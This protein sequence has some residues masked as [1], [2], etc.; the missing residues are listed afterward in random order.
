[1]TK[2]GVLIVME[3][4]E[5]GSRKMMY[6]SN[7]HVGFQHVVLSILCVGKNLSNTV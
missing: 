1:M 6:G 4:Y 5:I 2:S 7:M 3:D